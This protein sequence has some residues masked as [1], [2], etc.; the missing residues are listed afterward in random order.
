MFDRRRRPSGSPSCP[1]PLPP[2]SLS[3][4]RISLV[5]PSPNRCHLQPLACTQAGSRCIRSTL[6]AAPC[7]TP[8]GAS[9]T[10]RSGTRG[11]RQRSTTRVAT[12]WTAAPSSP[13]RRALCSLCVLLK[14]NKDL[15][16]N[17]DHLDATY[18]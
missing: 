18:I 11:C 13:G 15:N 17:T 16:V 12:A 8:V 7:S 1:F 2:P 14:V 4:L 6:A 3:P 5:F 10:P 9:P